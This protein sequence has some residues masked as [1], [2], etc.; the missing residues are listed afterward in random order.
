VLTGSGPLHPAVPVPSAPTAS[1]SRSPVPPDKGAQPWS[2]AMVARDDRTVTVYSGAARCQ[3]LFSPT[4]RVTVQDAQQVVIAVH[5]TVTAAPDCASSGDA[6]PVTVELPTALGGR[7]LSD[8]AGTG[9]AVYHQRDLPDVEAAGWQPFT[10]EWSTGDTSWR[11]G[12]NGPAGSEIDLVAG[13]AAALG[14]TGNASGQGLTVKLGTREGTVVSLAQDGWRVRWQV[15]G[16]PYSLEFIPAEG[17]HF[18]R[19]QFTGLLAGLHWS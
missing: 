17:G 18:S 11:Q 3:L 6:V 19:D 14:G 8:A 9:V 12:Y 10:T 2:V 5:G 4:A 7:A 15:D 16:V 1:P 13:P